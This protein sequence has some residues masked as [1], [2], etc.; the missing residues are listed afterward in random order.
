MELKPCP[1]CG[2]KA[3]V[4][5]CEGYEAIIVEHDVECFLCIWSGE[6]YQVINVELINEWTERI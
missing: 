3:S 6:V 4:E 1:F 5:S 2:G